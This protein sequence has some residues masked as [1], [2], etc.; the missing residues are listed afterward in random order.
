ME[1]VGKIINRLAIIN[2][3]DSNRRLKELGLSENEGSILMILKNGQSIYQESIIKELQVDK[4]AVTRLLK[5]MESKGL[6]K[7]IQSD[8]DKRYFLIEITELGV[9]KQVLVDDVF[10]Q[11]DINIVDGLSFEEQGE[12]KR[13]LKVIKNNLMRGENNE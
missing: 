4:S 13:M 9:K 8:K 7:R 1:R 5:S 10:R 12:L 2:H 11:K 3:N 6:I